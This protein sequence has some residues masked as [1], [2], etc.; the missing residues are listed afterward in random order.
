MPVH[1]IIKKEIMGDKDARAHA[2]RCHRLYR[3]N[4]SVS[5]SLSSCELYRLPLPLLV[6]RSQVPTFI[7]SKSLLAQLNFN[8]LL[9]CSYLMINGRKSSYSQ[10]MKRL[11]NPPETAESPPFI[12]PATGWPNSRHRRVQRSNS[13]IRSFKTC[14][15]HF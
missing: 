2:L 11:Q 15:F 1:P 9:D 14:C 12:L 6:K 5:V 4:S 10:P 13:D 3:S 8:T 7:L